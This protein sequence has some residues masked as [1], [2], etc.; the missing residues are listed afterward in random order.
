MLIDWLPRSLSLSRAPRRDVARRSLRT[1]RLLQ[2]ESLE[3]RLVLTMTYHAGG[4]LLTNVEAQNVYLGADW[5]TDPTLAS[6]ATQLDTFTNYLVTSPVM[7]L[8]SSFGYN[9]YRGTTTAGVVD[10]I[11]NPSVLSDQTIQFDLQQL[12]NNHMV[13]APDANSLYIV[14]VDPGTEVTQ[15]GANSVINF[16]GYHSSFIGTDLGSNQVPIRY[17]VMPYPG[18]PNPTPGSQGFANAME[19]LEFVTSHE[20]AEAVTDPDVGLNVLSWYDEAINGETADLAFDTGSTIG[21]YFVTNLV[22]TNDPLDTIVSAQNDA[23]PFDAPTGLTAIQNGANGA[24]LTWTNNFGA[25]GSTFKPQSLRVYEVNGSTKTLVGT[26][27]PSTTSALVT[28]LVPGT[29]NT[30]EVAAVDGPSE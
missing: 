25:F 2:V 12:I 16:L 20:L 19:E 27:S 6:Q 23:L 4:D 14:Y 10:T 9:V 5:K 30:F 28:N 18:P 13:Q 3:A 1:A 29:T 22:D 17:A 26:F 7:D 8:M 11:T 15:G 21:G 24:S